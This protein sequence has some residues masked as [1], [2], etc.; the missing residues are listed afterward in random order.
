MVNFDSLALNLTRV[1]LFPR[2]DRAGVVPP[3]TAFGDHLLPA[4][5]K[6]GLTWSFDKIF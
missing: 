6:E 3:A 1:D 5:E 4:L 2:F